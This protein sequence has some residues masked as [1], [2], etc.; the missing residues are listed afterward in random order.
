MP[1]IERMMVQ[2]TE[3]TQESGSLRIDLYSTIEGDSYN[4]WG[5]RIKSDTSAKTVKEAIDNHP[6]CK[7]LE[8]HINS[9]GGLVSEGY[10]IYAHLQEYRRN[11]GKVTAYIDGFANSIASIIAMASDSIKMHCGAVMIIHNMM[12][13]CWGNASE[14]RKM[15]EDLDKMMEGNRQIYLN[16]ANEKLTEEKLIEMLDAETTLTAQEC[17]EYGLCDE[18]LDAPAVDP[19]EGQSAMKEHIDKMK[20]MAAEM[21][22]VRAA[23][24]EAMQM[25]NAPAHNPEPEPKKTVDPMQ[26]IAKFFN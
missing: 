15:A 14:H 23:Y 7:E 16:R 20:F 26:S 8:L 3:P 21:K 17:M 9:P 19:E 24:A 22:S 5:D 18:I 11:G 4:W 10:G 13:I 12:D 6:S 1:R 2:V 25:I